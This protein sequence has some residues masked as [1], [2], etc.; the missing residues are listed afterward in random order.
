MH[1]YG[2]GLPGIALLL[3]H[4]ADPAAVRGDG[5]SAYELALQ[6]PFISQPRMA[7]DL[8]GVPELLPS[9][10]PKPPRRRLE[11]CSAS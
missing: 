5:L 3:K 9:G 10:R 11:S 8:F 2:I 6:G 1:R 4:G 7:R